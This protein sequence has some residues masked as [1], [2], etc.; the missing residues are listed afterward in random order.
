MILIISENDDA[1]TDQVIQWLKYFQI[2][3]LRIN[4]NN[5]FEFQHLSIDF[6]GDVLYSIKNKNLE[7]MS[8]KITGYWYRRG[9]LSLK[10]NPIKEQKIK[11]LAEASNSFLLNEFN[12][13]TEFLYYHL[14]KLNFSIGNIYDNN[15]NKIVNLLKANAC[16]IKT[17]RTWIL[18]SKK[19]ILDLLK[20]E[21]NI[22]TKPITQRGLFFEN[23]NIFFDGQSNLIQ[24]KIANKFP[25]FFAPTLFQE[26]IDKAYELRVFYLN[27]KCY[28]SAIFSQMDEMTKVDFRNYNFKKPN[29]TPPYNLPVNMKRKIDKFMRQNNMKSGSLD[30]L[31]DKEKNYFFLEVNPIG[32][33]Y[34]VS[35]PCNFYLEKEIAKYFQ[36]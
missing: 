12:A 32:Q 16:G 1:S 4:N 34:Q 29:R 22:L 33:F 6:N 28:T 24:T 15:T 8:T 20:K 14:H 21:K 35:Y 3:F 13:I 9:K 30:V 11:N 17:P 5:L 25:D 23:E 26:Y 10:I 2:K 19:E 27:G 18:T 36:K 7:L 31:V